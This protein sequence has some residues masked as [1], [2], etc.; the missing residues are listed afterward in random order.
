MSLVELTITCL[1]LSVVLALTATMA[2]TFVG[3]N[4]GSLQRQHDTDEARV[5]MAALA[6]DLDRITPP[7]AV[8]GGGG[9]VAI[10][11]AQSDRLVVWTTAGSG[12][13]TGLTMVGIERCSDGRIVRLQS[14]TAPKTGDSLCQTSSAATIASNVGS[15]VFV[16]YTK[17]PQP[18]R[19]AK[20]WTALST[21]GS[22][23]AVLTVAEPAV[24]NARPP[25]PSTVIRRFNLTQWKEF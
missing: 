20:P 15:G 14:D 24:G 3:S 25:A 21:V 5:A 13:A 19:I 6:Q 23:E 11:D 18:E 9:S 2:I 8:D 12:D 17:A 1:M 4:R 10:V 7:G 16:Y 22:I